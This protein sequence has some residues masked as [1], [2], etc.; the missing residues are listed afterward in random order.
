MIIVHRLHDQMIKLGFNDGK[1][2]SEDLKLSESDEDH[3]IQLLQTGRCSSTITRLPSS[4]SI[5]HSLGGRRYDFKG[6]SL[7]LLFLQDRESS[8]S[9]HPIIQRNFALLQLNLP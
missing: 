1:S 4:Y 6:P 5:G 2:I 7:R 9:K 8:L 3:F